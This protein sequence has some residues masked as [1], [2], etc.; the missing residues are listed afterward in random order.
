MYHV[1]K[2][3]NGKMYNTETA[4][5][6]ACYSNNVS[7]TDFSFYIERLYKKKTGE[8]F[9]Y[10]RGGAASKYSESAG[11]NCWT[12]GYRIIPFTINDAKG[13]M[14]NTQALMNTKP[15]L[16]KLKSDERRNEYDY[17]QLEHRSYDWLRTE[18][19][20]LHRLFHRRYVW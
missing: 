20:F 12:G 4:R 9:L 16:A 8:Y 18:D 11:Q 13:W 3:I 15:N 19:H 17:C 5:E 2:I 14:E 6:V 1:K 7:V 10:G